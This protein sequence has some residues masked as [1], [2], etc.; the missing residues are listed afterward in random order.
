MN[1]I[2]NLSCSNNFLVFFCKSVKVNLEFI[3][4][5]VSEVVKVF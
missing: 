3:V 4:F 5:F 2:K 1:E